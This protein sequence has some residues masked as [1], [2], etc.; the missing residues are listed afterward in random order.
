MAIE[1]VKDLIK[2]DQTIAKDK[3]DIY[4]TENVDFSQGEDKLFKVL[5]VE[6]KVV[7][8]SSTIYKGKLKLKGYL[9]TKTL[10]MTG[11]EG[12][13]AYKNYNIDF[14][15]EISIEGIEDDM[16]AQVSSNIENLDYTIIDEEK[17][18]IKTVISLDVKIMKNTVINV[19][20]DISGGNGIQVLKENVKY[21][22]VIGENSSSTIVKDGFELTEELADILE[23]LNVDIKAYEKEIKI[24]DGKVIVAGEVKSSVMYIEDSEENKISSIT[25][26]TPF[27]HFVD[28]DNIN[29]DM[30]CNI[31]LN[32]S[33]ANYEIQRDINGRNRII[34]LESLIEIDA[35]VYQIK[36]KEIAIDTYSTNSEIELSREN[37]KI[38]E[39]IGS[40]SKFEMVKD[41]IDVS[42]D[43]EIIKEIYKINVLP[44]VTDTRIIENK[45]IIEGILNANMLYLG[46]ESGE[47]KNTQNDF[48]FKT[49]IDM[50]DISEDMDLEID[51]NIEGLNY[52]KTS[53]RE[54]E[55]SSDV[56]ID[57]LINRI[58][59]IDIVTNA[60][61]IEDS[62]EIDKGHSIVIYIVKENDTLWDIA[63]RYHTTTEEL[64]RVND[65]IAPENLMPG[66]KIFIIK[67]VD[68]AI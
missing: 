22:E 30:G 20:K 48:P 32:Y 43:D 27:T 34:D 16:K 10:Y 54:V 31:K 44:I 23:V 15:E 3:K 50:D 64:I 61:E 21:N 14:N 45:A 36:E 13:I 24:V 41:S 17:V 60:L 26:S 6:G 7:L 33:D 1:L 37:V 57:T 38:T 67:T 49:Y 42:Y 40:V 4:I 55:I 28:I 59:N 19:L 46:E 53:S 11:E 12:R 58:K 29:K 62:S 35:K 47:I 51:M 56:R 2:I 18:E 9:N 39:N 68:V 66:E 8:D 25:N 63:K 65:I 5:N 52:K